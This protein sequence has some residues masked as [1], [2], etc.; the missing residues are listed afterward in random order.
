MFGSSGYKTR[1]KGGILQNY[2]KCVVLW[3]PLVCTP[4]TLHRDL[5]LATCSRSPIFTR[6]L[7]VVIQGVGHASEIE[8]CTAVCCRC[9]PEQH[10]ENRKIKTLVNTALNPALHVHS[11]NHVNFKDGF[12]AVDEAKQRVKTGEATTLK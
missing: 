10:E 1:P 2:I 7:I 3:T 4:A 8:I 12:F 5:S 6:H 9:L 11:V